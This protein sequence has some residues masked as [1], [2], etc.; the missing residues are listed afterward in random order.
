[1]VHILVVEDDLI[2]LMFLEEAFQGEN[3]SVEIES[4]GNGQEA[5]DKLH[6]GYRPD[7]IISDL[8]MPTMDGKAM[9]KKIKANDHL[10]VIPTII[11]STSQDDHDI[12]D[13]YMSHANAYLSKPSTLDG[14]SRLATRIQE[15][16]CEEAKIAS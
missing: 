15:F 8:K 9:L 2:D 13:C 10:K 14:Y 5:L 6:S 4:A 3:R 1:M 7:I 11:L 12:R 16:W